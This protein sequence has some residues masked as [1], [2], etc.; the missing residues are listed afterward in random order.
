MA[1]P[2]LVLAEPDG[3][4]RARPG[5]GVAGWYVAD[6]RLLR[7]LE[8]GVDG[9]DLELVRADATGTRHHE[10][11]HVARGLGDQQPDPTVVLRH[12]RD[13]APDTLTERVHVRSTARAPVRV[14]LHLDVEAD[15]APVHAVKQGGRPDAVAPA[16]DGDGALRWAARGR[17]VRLVAAG[18]SVEVAERG[19]RL[20]WTLDL[21]P[22]RHAEVEVRAHAEGPVRFASGAAEAGGGWADR[23]G[24]TAPDPRLARLV[25]RSL[26]DLDG[27]LLRDGSGDDHAAADHTGGDRFLAAGSPW[28]LTL[29]GRD[30]LWAARLL[31]PVDVDLALS[32]LRVLARRQG[33]REDPATEE[34]PGKI[35]HEVRDPE[36]EHLL[37]PLYYGTVDATPLF[38]CLLADAARWGADPDQVRALLPAARRCLEWQLAQSRETGWLRYVDESGSGLSNQGWKDSHDSVQF[39]DGRLADAPIAL[40]EVQAYA[41]EAAVAGA[42]LLAAY[43]EPEVPGLAAWAEDLRTRFRRDFWVETPDGGHVAIALDRDGTRVDAVTSNVGH[44]L[45]TG[46]LDADQSARVAALLVGELRSGFGV[47][48]LT[49]R[50]PRFS[51]LSYHGGSVWPHDTAIAVRGLA[52]EG[53]HVEAALLAAEL[54]DAAEGFDHRLPELYAGDTAD[55][56]P[57]P[58]AYPAACR[59]QAWSAAGAVAALVAATGVRPDGHGGVEVPARVGTSLGPFGLTG[60][61]VAGRDL[62]V[63]VDADGRVV[64]D[65]A[66]RSASA[67]AG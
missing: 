62:G 59:P 3:C 53:H 33:E 51:E 21:E 16:T 54:V 55:A 29:F 65:P 42:A 64:V 67:A 31:L 50:S 66:P 10:F 13:L 37:P 24:V 63:A 43:D 39:A 58:A 14:V 49:P 6:V 2:G 35:L 56:V 15:L 9:S 61:R 28:F 1:A 26:G 38:V 5:G 30:S 8:L 57:A 45:G 52:A 18:A 19:A 34:Q 12:V 11:V 47:H 4:L 41:H 22:G 44:L 27:L 36:L 23:V 40:C 20:T 60:L 25:G 48:T 7:R 17:E 32:T 46:V